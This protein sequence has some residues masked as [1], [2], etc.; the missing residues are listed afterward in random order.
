MDPVACAS[1]GS[2]ARFDAKPEA[3]DVDLARTAVV[4]VDLQNDFYDV[5]WCSK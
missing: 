3:V 4:V 5:Y 1:V 2:S